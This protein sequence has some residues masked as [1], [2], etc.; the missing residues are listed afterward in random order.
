[1]PELMTAHLKTPRFDL[2]LLLT[3]AVAALVLAA[4]GT[5]GLFAYH[6]ARR[7]REIGIRIALGAAPRMILATVVRDGLMLG[8]LGVGFGAAASILLSR[9]VR[10]L[11]AGISTVDPIAL[12]TSAVVL[13]V[14]ALAAC[15]VPARRASSVDPAVTL[16][17]E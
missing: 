1:M 3:F 5:Y 4:I 14:I 11:V 10:G 12:G 17:A 13:I 8:L 9:V 16:A 2:T 15:L 6:V 7:T